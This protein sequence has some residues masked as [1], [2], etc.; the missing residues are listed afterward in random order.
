MDT[1]ADW[2][3][4]LIWQYE[5][6]VGEAGPRPWGL[7]VRAGGCGGGL[8][9]FWHLVTSSDATG[10]EER[11]RLDARRC[12]ILPQVW[13]LLERLADGDPSVH[14][15]HETHQRR[16]RKGKVR[17]L[18]AA[19]ADYNLVV[20][21]GESRQSLILITAY[22]VRGGRSIGR[23]ARRKEKSWQSGLSRADYFRHLSWRQPLA[24]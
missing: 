2:W 5:A 9:S 14:W 12:E 16:R 13:D 23:I 11:R 4:S 15:W 24:A 18:F 21:L 10:R 20:V 3:Q 19:T 8:G 22:P 7:P 1:F 17:R 6:M